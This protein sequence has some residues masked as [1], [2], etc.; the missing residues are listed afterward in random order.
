[1]ID[2][3]DLM[4]SAA[5]R[6]G[7]RTAAPLWAVLLAMWLPACGSD[8]VAA[9]PPP[10]P[11]PPPVTTVLEEGSFSGLP[12]AAGVA[13]EFMTNR[14]GDLEF[15]VDWTFASND[16]NLILFRGQCTEDE[17]LADACNVA[18]IADSSTAKPERAGITGAPA[19]IYTLVVFNDGT[20]EESFSYQV[21]LTTAGSASAT[22][23]RSSSLAAGRAR[24][25]AVTKGPQRP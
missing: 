9:P 20:T 5:A 6:E 2:K 3:E 15:I 4:A 12:P 24:W 23:A 11:P 19:G 10:P 16:L 18:D 13:G 7:T 22:A 8:R 17:F 25:R 21:L 1:L 14:M